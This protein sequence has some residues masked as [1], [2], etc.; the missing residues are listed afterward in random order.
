MSVDYCDTPAE[1]AE[2]PDAKAWLTAMANGNPQAFQFMWQFWC[3]SHMF[4][5]LVDR[6]K[7]VDNERAGREM[8]LLLAQISFNPFYLEYK[9]QLFAHV[10]QGF[11]NWIDGDAWRN[12]GDPKKMAAADV[13]SCGDLNLYTHVAFI[14]GGWDAMRRLKDFRSYDSN[15]DKKESI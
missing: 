6:D 14:T 1:V 11:N 15:T 3:F 12:S 7:P 5:D 2:N 4:D 10:V 9:E 13:I 8:V